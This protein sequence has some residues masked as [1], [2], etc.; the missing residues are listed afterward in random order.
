METPGPATYTMGRRLAARTRTE[1]SANYTSQKA[2]GQASP[3]L[4]SGRAM[5]E[6]PLSRQKVAMET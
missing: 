5:K 1:V 2:R 3:N 6:V 4:P